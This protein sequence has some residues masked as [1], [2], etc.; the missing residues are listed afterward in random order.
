MF[1]F[2]FKAFNL[3]NLKAVQEGKVL[4]QY[5]STR[6]EI[7]LVKHC[8]VRAIVK[9]F[10]K[11][12]FL[13]R[14][15]IGRFLVWRETKAYKKLGTLKG[16][17]RMYKVVDGLA[18]VIEAIPGRT[19]EDITE[20]EDLPPDFFPMLRDL[21][22]ECHE[23]GQAHCDIKKS[24]NIILGND[25]L[26]YIIDW[27]AS[28]NIREF[29]YFPFSSIFNLF[30][31]DDYKAITKLKLRLDPEA[32]SFEEKNWYFKCHLLENRIRGIRNAL[33]RLLK[34]IA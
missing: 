30:I 7:Y 3:I 18:L 32:V 11:N 34:K 16:I 12:R 14:N 13:F 25:N 31:I 26:P 21:V 33:R 10:S 28:I 5:S 1:S 2:M 29:L 23:R 24:A 4:R 19:L 9:D 8:G 20:K 6:P 27:G 22:S 17:P 15:I